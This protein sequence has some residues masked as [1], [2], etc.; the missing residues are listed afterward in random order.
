[1]KLFLALF[2]LATILGHAM[3]LEEKIGQML[4]VHF[5]GEEA[6]EGARQLIEEVHVGGFI[7]YNW[8]N[9]LHNPEQVKALSD[10]LQQMAQQA[11]KPALFIAVD[12]EG[13]RVARLTEGFT[14]LLSNRAIAKT[15]K[16]ELAEAQARLAGREMR[17]VGVNMNLAPV[18]DVQTNPDNPVIGDRAY[19]SDP[20][21]VAAFGKAALKG[22]EHAG[23][24]AVLKHYPGYGDVSVDPHAELPVVRKDREHLEK[25]ELFPFKNLA[26]DAKAIMT[27]HIVV[28]ALDDCCATLSKKVVGIL[29]DEYQFDGLIISDSL[30]MQGLLNCCETI[31]EAAIRAIASGHDVLILGGKQLLAQQKGLELTVADVKRIHSAICE[32]VKTGRIKEDQIDHSVSRIIR[33]KNGSIT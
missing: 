16:P 8:A 27:A 14:P 19:G 30:V 29:R 3:T 12:Q 24:I 33:S 6:N 11:G 5:N 17:L 32:A 18:V 25:E 13:G 26:K 15:G 1:M 28:P 22:Y 7:Y 21:I 4:I 2:C 31:E 20:E 23:I 10:S 9:G